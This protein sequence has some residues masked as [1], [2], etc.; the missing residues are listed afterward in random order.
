M[1]PGLMAIGEAAC[2]SVHGANRLGC[3]SLLELIVFGKAAGERAALLAGHAH[4]PLPASALEPLLTRFDELR[5]SRGTLRPN[6]IRKQSQL[7]MQHHASIFRTDAL[8]HTGQQQLRDS[9]GMMQHE[10]HVADTSLIWNN[11]LLDALE[12]D[13]LLRQAT[14]TLA[15]ASARTESRGAHWREDYPKRNDADWLKHSIGFID[16]DG[17]TRLLTRPVH[18]SAEEPKTHATLAF[19]PEERTY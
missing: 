18:L 5:Q 7:A 17:N 6:Q 12:T 4:K 1:V 9:W 19:P 14:V 13:N 15:C 3:N 2:T 16:D 8:L 10:L 11:D